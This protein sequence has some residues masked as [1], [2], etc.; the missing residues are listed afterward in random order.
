MMSQPLG[1]AFRLPHG[2][3]NAMVLLAVTRF[4][5]SG[6]QRRYAACARAL[7]FARHADG[8]ALAC[9]KL[10]GGLRSLCADLRIRSPAQCG[11]RRD[12]FVAAVPTMAAQALAS[13]HAAHNPVAA[14]A[15]EAERLYMEAWD[16]AAGC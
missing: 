14:S 9:E 3:C 10:V 11:V 13:P 12:A 8:E 4:S 6:A 2:A 5:I 1:A 16:C 15:A 7:G